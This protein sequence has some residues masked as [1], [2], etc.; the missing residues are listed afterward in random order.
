MRSHCATTRNRTRPSPVIEPVPGDWQV[1][2][3]THA[4]E[5]PESHTL[6]FSIPVPREGAAKVVYR[7]RI[8]G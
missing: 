7:V 8:R 3:S 2:N 6:R 1:L 4:F 5:K